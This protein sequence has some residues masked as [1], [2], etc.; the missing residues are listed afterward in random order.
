MDINTKTAVKIREAREH[1]GYTQQF[2]ADNLDM[3]KNSYSLIELGKT[4]IYLE[5]LFKICALLDEPVAKIL[6][7]QNNHV[8]WKNEN[9]IVLAQNN[10]G[11]LHFT[12]SEELLEK[13]KKS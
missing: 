2:M 10:N 8:I 7:I 12:L 13:L 6:S 4:K 1:K 9:N 11:T 3:S 5:V